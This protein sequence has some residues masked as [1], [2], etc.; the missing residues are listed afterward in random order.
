MTHVRRLAFTAFLTLSAI[1]CHDPFSP[2]RVVAGALVLVPPAEYQQ[3]WL[4]TEQC[5]GHIGEIGRVKWYVVPNV[6]YF[7]YRGE[8][9][10][11]YWW[12]SHDILLAGTH[13]MDEGTVRHEMLH[14][15]LNTADHP[16]EYFGKR[17]AG[18]VR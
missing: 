5:S 1:G 3:W 17:C 14:D 6:T 12:E 7:D 8:R 13:V 9:Y 15:L 2:Q 18:V 16:A 10:D 4:D 11:G